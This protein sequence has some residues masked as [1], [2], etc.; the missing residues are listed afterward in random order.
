MFWGAVIKRTPDWSGWS[1]TV[2]GFCLSLL[3]KFFFD[4][5]WLNGFL[6]LDP[7]LSVRE[8][9]DYLF[10]AAVF[11]N[12]LIPSLWFLGS[13]FFYRELT[14]RRK[15]EVDLMFHNMRTPVVADE[16]EVKET[17]VSQS[18]LLG[19]FS[20]AY[21]LFLGAFALI[22][23]NPAGRTAFLFCGGVLLVIG[24]ALRAASQRA[25]QRQSGG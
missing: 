11:V 19:R 1:T 13:R 18:R 12:T 22:P 17:D 15:E 25:L 21:G 3:L 20:I 5:E 4:A 2:V 10:I 7:A 24:L 9:N 6:D 14:G 8:S 23:N 16:A